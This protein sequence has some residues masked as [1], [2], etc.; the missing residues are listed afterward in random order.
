MERQKS[1][2]GRKKRGPTAAPG[3]FIALGKQ[4]KPNDNEVKRPTSPQH[5]V[6]PSGS[7]SLAKK[8]KLTMPLFGSLSRGH[9]DVMSSSSSQQ[10]DEIAINVEPT[11]LLGAILTAEDEMNDDRAEGLLCGAVK[12]LRRDRS[13]PDQVIFLTL[14][15]L[16]KYRPSLFT[17]EMVIEA[18][19]GLLKREMSLT[20]KAKGNPL[21]SVLAC[22]VLMN[23]FAEEE[24]WPDNFVKVFVDDS[25]GERVWVDRE[26]CKAFVEN[27]QTAFGTKKSAKHLL[28]TTAEAMR[29]ENSGSVSPAQV[30]DEDSSS[31]MSD[32]GDGDRSYSNSVSIPSIPRFPY[33]QTAIETYVLDIIREILNRRQPMDASSRNLIRLM[34]STSGYGEVR[35]MAAQRIDMWLQN[36][37]LTR[38]SQDLL[39]AV[40]TNC[41]KHDTNDLEVIGHLTKMR[42]KTKPLINHFLNCM[43]ELLSQHPENLSMILNHTIYNELS[44]SRNPNNMALLTLIFSHSSEAA[45]KILAEIFQDLLT[46]K[47]DYLKALRILLREIVRCTRLDMN[48]STFCLGLM[49]ER[50]EQ[51]FVDMDYSLKERYVLSIADLISMDILLS[52]GP[53]VRE[54]AAGL[55]QGDHKN[56]ELIHIFKKQVSIIQRDSV[57]WLHTIVPKI[58]ELKN[59]VYLHCLKKVLFLESAEH[60]YNKDNWPA[61]SERSLMLRLASESPVMEDTLM[62]LLVIGLLRELPLSAPDAV[63]LV[64][65]LVCRAATLYYDLGLVDVLQME[66]LEFIDALLNLCVYKHP[67]NIV[68]PSGYTAPNLAI[69]GLMWKAWLTLVIITAYNPTVFGE[70]AW[71]KYPQLQS[72]MEMVMTNNFTFPLPTAVTDENM[73]EE[74]RARERQIRQQEIHLILEFET[75]LAAATSKVTITESNSLLIGQLINNDPTGPARF[76]PAEILE[77]LKSL[78]HSLKLGQMLCRSR[79]PDFLLRIINRQGTSQSMPWLAELVDSSEGSLDVLPVQCLCEFL[80]HGPGQAALVSDVEDIFGGDRGRQKQKNQKH[81]QLLSRLQDLVHSTSTES[82]T[83]KEV[84]DYFLQRLSSYQ[85]GT[86]QQAVKGLAAVVK[87]KFSSDGED[88]SMDVDIQQNSDNDWLLV[89]MTS[90]PLF[91]E[92]KESLCLA[93]RKACQVETDPERINSYILF[94]SQY[95]LE[96][97][98]QTW[99]DLVLDVAQVLVERTSILNHILPDMVASPS[100]QHCQTLNAFIRLF[101]V[102]MRYAR[103][104]DKDTFSWSNTQDQILLQW[105]SGQSATVH[106]LVVHAMIVLLTYGKP[107]ADAKDPENRFYDELFNMWIQENNKMPSGYLLDTSEEALLLPDWLKLRMLRS[108]DERLVSA[109]LTEVEPS[110]LVLFVQSFGIPVSSM[111]RLLAALDQAVASDPEMMSQAVT[112]TAYMANLVDIQH[113]RGATGGQSFYQMLTK[114]KEVKQTEKAKNE[115]ELPTQNVWNINSSGELIL[116]NSV[117]KLARLLDQIFSDSISN[118]SGASKLYHCL[119]QAVVN[120]KSKAATI[121]KALDSLL[122]SS[123]RE[124]FAHKLYTSTHKS[125]PILKTLI[126]KQPDLHFDLLPVMEKLHSLGMAQKSFL[127]Q[128]SFLAPLVTQFLLANMKS[129]PIQTSTNKL[130]QD[131]INKCTQRNISPE[132]LLEAMKELNSPESLEQAVNQM[133][134]TFL[135]QGRCAQ[136]TQL[137]CRMLSQDVNITSLSPTSAVLLVDWISLLDPEI[138]HLCPELEE[139]LIFASR[140][141]QMQTAAKRNTAACVPSPAHLLALLTHH[142]SWETLTGC[143]VRLLQPHHIERF[144]PT[145]VLDFVWACGHVPKIWQGREKRTLEI[146]EKEDVLC[147]TSQQMCAVVDLILSE[148]EVIHKETSFSNQMPS[149][150]KAR[151]DLLLSCIS[152]NM[153]RVVAVV[154]HLQKLFAVSSG[155]KKKCVV[156]LATNLYLQFPYIQSWLAEESPLLSELMSSHTVQSQLDTI[157]HRLITSLGMIGNKLKIQSRMYDANIAC[158]KMA[159]HHPAIFLRQLPLIG[160]I[161]SGQSEFTAGEMRHTN[162]LLLYTHVLGLIELLQPHVYRPEHSGL[163]DILG[164]FFSLMQLHGEEKAF[165]SQVH[166]FVQILQNF[167]TQDPSRALPL[168]QKQ[169]NLLSNLSLVYPDMIELKALLTNLTLPRQS[170]SSQITP[171]SVQSVCMNPGYTSAQLMPLYAQLRT[172]SLEEVQSALQELDEISKRKIEILSYF[173]SQLSYLMNSPWDQCREVTFTLILRRLRQNPKKAEHFVNTFLDCLDSDNPNIVASALKNLAEFA[174]LCQE[175]APSLLHKAFTVSIKKSIDSSS[176]ISEALQ[177]INLH[178]ATVM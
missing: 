85:A 143:L 156:S 51:K 69:A 108:L 15:Y 46:N 150:K 132:I 11:E 164:S 114:N 128:K 172:N 144:D 66:R 9:T 79:N 112:D 54:A 176:Y 173:E 10:Y 153:K 20:F 21:V 115:E 118:E 76:P 142:T 95:A 175:E 124:H 141:S 93:L 123:K 70:T 96:E 12:H 33:Q 14:M 157:S 106:V 87:S 158:R 113:A 57:W 109:A 60:Y 6:S 78:N 125:C 75:H 133:M 65:Q 41:D 45:A 169:L 92:V 43:R 166:K 68:L 121:I 59:D 25:L 56:L 104:E 35:N 154:D 81:Q 155:L 145:S 64:D 67:E 147:L 23:A 122:S 83:M 127:G 58:V 73:I 167:L 146:E 97:P 1:I 18:F 22:N 178:S 135:A 105:E 140:L 37:K 48:F 120:D 61:E 29:G 26:D 2:L 152:D 4:S 165:G 160:A 63:E 129:K 88:E 62:R 101:L 136:G 117:D 7:S 177:M 34:T 36:P 27:I 98:Q 148:A 130:V 28:M 52:V 17:T 126:V 151:T 161:L 94:L 24:N 107:K 82:K 111:S 99:N 86:R 38:V 16:S 168:L 55:M 50:T 116:P 149:F 102:Y 103:K 19:C 110:Q 53:N 32:G 72:L 42:M 119:L 134:E 13:K 31:K 44:T 100:E 40:C 159:A 89:H 171:P 3:D 49:Q 170:E 5:M 131:F 77:Q 8:P 47:D 137:V 39:L 174:A 80:L 71:L 163:E 30:D 139:Q 162:R 91:D 84:L 74:Y 138:V 90:L